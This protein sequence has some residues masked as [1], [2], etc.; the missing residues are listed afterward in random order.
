MMVKEDCEQAGLK[1]NIQKM[2]IMASD[3]IT[4]QQIE[5]DSVKQWHILFSWA[6]KSL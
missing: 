5:G 2:K 6:P 3:L 4:L 1:L